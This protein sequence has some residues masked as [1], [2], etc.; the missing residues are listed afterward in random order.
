[1]DTYSQTIVTTITTHED[2]LRPVTISYFNIKT[3]QA[4]YTHMAVEKRSGVLGPE[5]KI[6]IS[7]VKSEARDGNQ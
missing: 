5:Y 6:N 4:F 1:M 3:V 7:D 2:P